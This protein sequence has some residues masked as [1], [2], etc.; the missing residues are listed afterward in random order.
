MNLDELSKASGLLDYLNEQPEADYFRLPFD[1]RGLGLMDY[2]LV[3]KNPMDLNQVGV[4]LQKNFYKDFNDFLCD[5]ILIWDNVRLY[6]LPDSN[7]VLKVECMESAMIRFCSLNSISLETAC[8]SSK[9]FEHPDWISL[10][11]KQSLS[12]KLQSLSSKKLGLLLD[13]IE[14]ECPSAVRKVSDHLQIRIDALDRTTFNRIS[15]MSRSP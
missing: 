13:V 15:E 1:F 3:V 11:E 9:V 2:P 4:K 7:L 8:K 14:T 6:H 10:N 12:E 5:L